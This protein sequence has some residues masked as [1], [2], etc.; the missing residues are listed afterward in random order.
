MSSDGFSL[1]EMSSKLVLNNWTEHI[2]KRMNDVNFEPSTNNNTSIVPSNNFITEKEEVK[3]SEQEYEEGEEDDVNDPFG[4]YQAPTELVVK[5]RTIS[6]SGPGPEDTDDTD[7]S[8]PNLETVKTKEPVQQL[9]SKMGSLGLQESQKKNGLKPEFDLDNGGGFIEDNYC[10]SNV[11]DQ[12][13]LPSMMSLGPAGDS[14]LVSGH[15]MEDSY[16]P[17][18]QTSGVSEMKTVEF[19]YKSSSS[20]KIAGDFNAWQ[21]QD[22]EKG[23][24]EEWKFLIDLPAGEYDYKYFINGEWVLDEEDKSKENADGVRNNVINVQF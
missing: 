20:V 23:G 14:S 19:K 15:F 12:K 6:Q 10:G 24:D 2:K 18:T 8:L 13:E 16:L 3:E 4:S 5:N 22:M 1:T 7:D 9:D 11:A 21:P 17:P